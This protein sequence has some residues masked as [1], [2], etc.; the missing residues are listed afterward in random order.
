MNVG[1]IN[2][3]AIVLIVVLL[4]GAGGYLWYSQM[5]TPAVEARTAAEAT[6]TAAQGELAAAKSK[7]AAAQKAIEDAKAEN[8][9]PDD[10]V[11]R[12]QLARKAV[13]PKKLI[14][15]A[16]I[17]LD[18]LAGRSGIR[19]A[20]SSGEEDAASA[21]AGGSNLQGATPI[22]L[23]FKAAGTYQEMML[24]MRL[25]EDTVVEEDGT[26]YARDRLFNVV[27]LQIGEEDEEESGSSGFGADGLEEEADANEIVAGE[28]EVLFTVTVRMYTSSTENAA[29]VGA[30]DPA[31]Q[32]TDGSAAGTGGAAGTGAPAD[33][34]TP[35]TGDPNAA[36]T[37]TGTGADPAAGGAAPTD[38]AG[39]GTT[40][41]TDT[42][43][44]APVAGGVPS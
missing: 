27:K 11:A 29:N 14:D 35:A 6:E 16:M 22:D 31:S 41:G 30:T 44:A 43:A 25:V 40:P 26:L 9:K 13:P 15:D 8:G 4:L 37:G 5:Y 23:K 21:P 18:D 33:G 12:V 36:G 39:A 24:F 28:G 19:T 42:G 3:G 32:P 10:S 38:Q 20:F 1:E 7:L 34:S 2:K 17:V